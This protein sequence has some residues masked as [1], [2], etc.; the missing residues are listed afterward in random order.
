MNISDSVGAAIRPDEDAR[1]GLVGPF[2]LAA[3]TTGV[4]AAAVLVHPEQF[5][6]QAIAAVLLVVQVRWMLWRVAAYRNQAPQRALA[7]AGYL[8]ALG[9]GADAVVH[10]ASLDV[11]HSAGFVTGSFFAAVLAFRAVLL[12]DRLGSGVPD[13]GDWTN[14]LGMVAGL[15]AVGLL[16]T[17]GRVLETGH[18]ST[19]QEVVALV[20]IALAIVL[21]GACLNVSLLAGMGLHPGLMGVLATFVLLVLAQLLL[22]PRGF[23]AV[24]VVGSLGQVAICGLAVVALHR[25]LLSRRF[26]GERPPLTTSWSLALVTGAI[27]VLVAAVATDAEDSF[28]AGMVGGLAALLGIVRTGGVVREI[29]AV[30][31]SLVEARTDELTGLGNR[32]G[33]ALALDRAM[34]ELAKGGTVALLAVDLRGFRDVNDRFGP[35]AGDAVLRAMA[36]RL[37]AVVPGTAVSRVSGDQFVIVLEEPDAAD[38]VAVAG[39]L[40]EALEQPVRIAAATLRLQASIGV[41]QADAAEATLDADELLRRAHVAMHVAKR[42]ER[43]VGHYDQAE[44]AAAHAVR[45]RVEE[46]NLLLAPVPDARAGRLV[47]HYQPQVDVRSGDV[48]GAEALVRWSHPKHGLLFPDAFIDLVERNGLMRPLTAIVLAS[49]A[50]QA[51]EWERQG[52]PLRVSVNLSSS[53]FLDGRLEQMVQD[54]LNVSGVSPHLLALEITESVLMENADA[55]PLVLQ[56]LAELRI[57]LSIDDF[58][59]GYSSLA[60]LADL[61]VDELKIDR[62]FVW[63]MLQDARTHAVV[64]GTIDLAHR[65]E[66]RVVAEGV[67]DEAMLEALRELGCDLSQGYLHSRPVDA[68]AFATWLDGRLVVSS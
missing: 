55:V 49:A 65:L 56:S 45:E 60:Y 41:A 39:R 40:V 18:W 21:L 34:T 44:D 24:E 67:E 58:G 61:P 22:M 66:L 23:H 37:R 26:E 62:S 57:S 1:P 51:A 10:A 50:E 48:A 27:L 9:L 42:A 46:L 17:D 25:P 33:L 19:T 20:Q 54:A 43:R 8:L 30:G 52:T 63:R 14:A 53:L 32:R 29:Q 13:L 11:P 28:A 36:A 35:A 38:P 4:Q 16:V 5:V 7:G 59:T 68:D 31:Q 15:V 2:A 12:W 3:V 64:A 47:V 6:L